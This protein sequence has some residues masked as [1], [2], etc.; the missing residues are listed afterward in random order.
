MAESA[1]ESRPLGALQLEEAVRLLHGLVDGV[2]RMVSARV[3]FIKGPILGLQGLRALHQ[4]VDVDVLVEPG[5]VEALQRGLEQLGWRVRVPSTTARVLPRH[6]TAYAH[7]LWP[8]EL[9]VHWHFPGFLA[10]PE[11]T[12]DALWAHRTTA[13]VAGREVPCPEPLAHVAVAGLHIL[14]Q[15]DAPG[16]REELARLVETVT[17]T[18]GTDQISQLGELAART[19]A[20]ATL[21][22]LLEPLGLQTPTPIASVEE[23]ADW[24]LRASSPGVRS[25]GWLAELGRTPFRRWPATLVHALLLTEAEIREAQPLAAPGRWGL[26]RARVRRLRLGLRDVPR[27]CRIVWRIR[28]EGPTTR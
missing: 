25:V 8:C 1:P 19:G 14:R 20:L 10:A 28:R 11:T 26:L 23:L 17:T 7:P 2:A 18:F 21:R 27:A 13:V 5:R 6:S 22:P 24:R 3:L 16:K 9:D 15:A 12:F 4:S